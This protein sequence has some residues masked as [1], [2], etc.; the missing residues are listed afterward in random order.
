[1][2]R[3]KTGPLCRCG[4]TEAQ[5]AKTYP[6]CDSCAHTFSE[7]TT[8]DVDTA[9]ESVT[10]DDPRVLHLRQVQAG[11]QGCLPD[12]LIDHAMVL[13]GAVRSRSPEVVGAV[14]AGSS[15]ADLHALAVCL[16]A[17][18][19]TGKTPVELLAWNDGLPGRVASS[20]RPCGTHAAFVRHRNNNETPCEECLTA[21]RAYQRARQRRRT[22]SSTVCG[23]GRV[24]SSPMNNA[25]RVAG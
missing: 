4:R 10:A 21:E 14:L 22:A 8:D 23:D 6:C 1:M 18:V 17:M 15:R 19:P 2:T 20:L 13:V 5:C 7:G 25:T 12:R 11:E 9:V 24:S 3:T 16:A